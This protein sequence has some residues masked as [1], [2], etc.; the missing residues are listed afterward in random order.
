MFSFG[1]SKLP[2]ST[3]IFNMGTSKYCPSKTLGLCKVADKCYAQKSEVMYKPVLP[4]RKRQQIFW[5]TNDAETIWQAF[6]K[7]ISRKR[8]KPDLFRFSE[9]GDFWGQDCVDKMD[10]VAGKLYNKYGIISY[11]F[12]ARSD[13]D[14][15]NVQHFFVK[16]SS[17]DNG[18][19]GRAVVIAKKEDLPAGYRL[20][21]GSCKTCNAC[22]Q[23]DHTNVAFVGH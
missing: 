19:N 10:Y 7:A 16:G 21:P 15:S 20:C 9:S 5:L 6:D 14:F 12:T 3:M 2:K 4:Y 17:H 18:N 1:N 23:H 11:G 8:N 22:S 13:L